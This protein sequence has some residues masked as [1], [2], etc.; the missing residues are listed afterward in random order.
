VDLHILNQKTLSPFSYLFFKSFAFHF[1]QESAAQ[2]DTEFFDSA[3]TAIMRDV[4][5]GYKMAALR[6]VQKL[7]LNK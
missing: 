2:Y 5:F 7:A 3:G 6:E 4:D 1:C